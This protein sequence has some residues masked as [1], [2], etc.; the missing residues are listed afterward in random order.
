V[1]DLIAYP[2]FRVAFAN[3][4]AAVFARCF[5]R[6]FSWRPSRVRFWIAISPSIADSLFGTQ[7]RFASSPN[8]AY[9]WARRHDANRHQLHKLLFCVR[10]VLSHAQPP[11]ASSSAS[12]SAKRANVTSAPARI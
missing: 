1:T 8:P 12:P 7:Q 4:R 2:A 6:F 3:C 5:G 11:F 10:D 9:P